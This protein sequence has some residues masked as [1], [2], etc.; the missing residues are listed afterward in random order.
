[1]ESVAELLIIG[2]GPG[3][4]DADLAAKARGVPVVRA[5]PRESPGDREE[6]PG[7][8]WPFADD[9][10]PSDGA[11]TFPRAFLGGAGSVFVDGPAGLRQARPRRVLIAPRLRPARPSWWEGPARITRPGDQAPARV[12]VVGGGQTGVEVAAA[13]AALCHEV[14]LVESADRILPGWDADQAATAREALEARGVVVLAGR[15]AVACAGGTAG[16]RVV[17]RAGGGAPDRTETAAVAVPALG[18]RPVLGG[19]G[20]E[21]T[22]ALL[23]RH[24]HLEVDSRCETAERGL[25]AIGAAL[26]LPLTPA[27]ARGQ[28]ALVAAIAAGDSPA[29]LRQALV[30]RVISQPVPLLAIGL[31]AAGA[32]AR[33][34]R[35]GTGRAQ[36]PDGTWVRCVSDLE[37]GAVI[38]LQA[39]GP[40]AGGFQPGAEAVFDD[41][42]KVEPASAASEPRVAALAPLLATARALSTNERTA[43]G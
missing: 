31:S 25:Y 35:A 6:A 17:L 7:W 24:G 41:R 3:A 11:S 13:W 9:T 2:D 43:H 18:W 30:P 23:D 42:R 20:L 10:A 39:A 22:R 37:T 28:A 12:I 8:P 27:G 14:L 5:A 21:R 40:L 15:R 4:A 33:G 29:P 38:G 36:A 34:I 19:C 1:M 16:T 26:S 32:A